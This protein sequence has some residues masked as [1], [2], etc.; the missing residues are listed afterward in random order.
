MRAEPWF[1]VGEHDV[2]PETLLSFLGMPG[3]LRE[4][5]L[6]AHA[7]LYQPT[8]WRRTQQRIAAG[9]VLEVLPYVPP[10]AGEDA[11]AAPAIAAAPAVA[12]SAVATPAVAQV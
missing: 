7:D 12:T 4:E 6:R 1:F 10:E 11:A 9:E 2:F 3:P 5:Y 8:F